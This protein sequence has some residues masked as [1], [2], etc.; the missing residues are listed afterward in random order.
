MTPSKSLSASLAAVALLSLTACGASS[1]ATAFSYADPTAGEYQLRRN[2]SLSTATHLVLDLWGPTATGSGVSVA[3][4]TDS[5]KAVWA[6]VAASDAAG[7]WIQ[8]GTQFT[9]GTA[10][11]IIKAT[12]AG[13][14]LKA[15][16]AQKGTKNPVSLNGPLLRVALDL[17]ADVTPGAGVPLTADPARCHVLDG[18]G[19]IA[20]VT[21]SVGALTAS[22]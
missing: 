18:T 4:S 3:L 6:N 17:K 21:V 14:V 8:N 11:Q 15:T 19:T 12:V 22:R 9:L 20:A 13:N 1:S 7:T 16:V 10:P 2:A 5:A